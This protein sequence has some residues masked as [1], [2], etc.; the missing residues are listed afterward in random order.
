MLATL[1]TSGQ[2]SVLIQSQIEVSD[3]QDAGLSSIDKIVHEP[4]RMAILAVLDGVQDADFLFLQSL[5]GLS[6]GN[7][8]SHL[9]RLEEAGYVG[10]TKTSGAVRPHTSIT[11]TDDG[12]AARQR[13]WAALEALHAA[14][15]TRP[16]DNPT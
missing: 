8:S 3:P 1:P 12:R 2:L 9:A 5:L 16:T 4:A 10:V 7:L 14:G 15:G 6:K 13:H 11:I